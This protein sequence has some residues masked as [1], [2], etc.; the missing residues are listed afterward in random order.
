MAGETISRRK[1]GYKMAEQG[2]ADK[3]A[4]DR[5]RDEEEARKIERLGIV[6]EVK[7]G[8][9]IVHGRSGNYRRESKIGG[10]SK[11]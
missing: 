10:D 8:R 3:G 2:W 7:T 4:E 5:G 6:R 1:L 9:G 11:G